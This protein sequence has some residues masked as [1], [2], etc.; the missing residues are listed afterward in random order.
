MRYKIEAIRTKVHTMKQ[1][2]GQ[3]G[4]ISCLDGWEEGKEQI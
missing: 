1:H 4:N 2:G 3:K